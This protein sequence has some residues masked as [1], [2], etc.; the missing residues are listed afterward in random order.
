MKITYDPNKNQRNIEERDLPFDLVNQF[1]WNTAQIWQDLRFDYGEIR[2]NALGFINERLYSLT[3][4]P[5]NDG[6]RVI[7]FRKANKR[8][9]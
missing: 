6:I 2:L 7:S 9:I 3:F 1:D 5:L 8:E 4:K